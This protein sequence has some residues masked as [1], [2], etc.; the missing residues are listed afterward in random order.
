MVDVYNDITSDGHYKKDD[1]KDYACHYTPYIYPPDLG[2]KFDFIEGSC[3]IPIICGLGFCSSG[4]SI[5]CNAHNFKRLL[6]IQTY[7]NGLRDLLNSEKYIKEMISICPMCGIPLKIYKKA[8]SRRWYDI[9]Y[10][11]NPIIAERFSIL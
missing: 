1:K 9:F 6:G 2:K 10:K 5:C 11:I 3:E 4:Y 8:V 7:F